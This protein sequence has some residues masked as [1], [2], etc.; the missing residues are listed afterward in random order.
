MRK[1]GLE[2]NDKG[3]KKRKTEK[4]MVGYDLER[5]EGCWRVRRGCEKSR[6]VEV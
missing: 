4:E 6:Q 5:Y 3:K 1:N 2:M